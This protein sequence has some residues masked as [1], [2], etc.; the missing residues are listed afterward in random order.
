MLFKAKTALAEARENLE[1]RDKLIALCLNS[2]F[3]AARNQN[4]QPTLD[5]IAKIEFP[6]EIEQLAVDRN[7]PRELFAGV[8]LFLALKISKEG[9]VAS[10]KMDH[11]ADKLSAFKTLCLQ[12]CE[13]HNISR[14]VFEYKRDNPD[15]HDVRKDSK[16]KIITFVPEQHDNVVHRMH[17]NTT[18]CLE[19][20]G[21]LSAGIIDWVAAVNAGWQDMGTHDHK[22]PFTEP[23]KPGTP[24]EIRF[25]AEWIP[26]H[27]RV[28]AA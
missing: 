18:R 21:D 2:H 16:G 19:G 13:R 11:E 23:V 26:Y 4:I 28:L 8:A 24:N 20:D 6:D 14:T 1:T 17:D 9:I 10:K 22:G 3:R 7:C 15:A 5:D 25:P 12:L 27:Q